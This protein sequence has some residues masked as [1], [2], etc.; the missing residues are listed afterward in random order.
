MMLTARSFIVA[1][2]LAAALTPHSAS[3]GPGAPSA[4]PST[5]LPKPPPDGE[6]PAL[7]TLPPIK[8]LE[9]EQESTRELD[10]LLTR[11]T[12]E[13]SDIREAAFADVEKVD[14]GLLPAVYGRIQN[15]RES[16]DRDQAP[17]TIAA[18][19]KAA[20]D[21]RKAEKKSKKSSASEEEESD[22][23]RFVLDEP[24]PKDATWREVVELLAITR[25]LR[26]MGTT[27][28]VREL[29]ELRANFG[30]M[31]RVDLM[32]Q[33]IALKDKAVPALLESKKHD[34]SVVREFADK[35]L[36]TLGK[37]TPGEAVSTTDPEVLA[38]TLKAFGYVREVEAVDVL[39]SFANHDR[40]KV[41]DAARQAIAAIGEAGRF[42]LRDAYQDLTGEK[43]DK[44]VPWDILAKRMFWLY[45]NARAAEVVRTFD[46]GTTLAKDKDYAGAVAAFDR[47]LAVDPQFDR[48]AEMSPAYF[49]LGKATSFDQPEERLARLRK[50]RRLLGQQP[51]P[52]IDA[53]IAFTE[54]KMLLAEGR[55]DRFLL[56]RAV[57]LDPNHNEAAAL[58]ASFDQEAA[59]EAQSVQ[60]KPPYVLA[61]AI[62]AVAA[63]LAGV[64]ALLP[65][66]RKQA[67]LKAPPA[68]AEAAKPTETT[69]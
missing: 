50:A 55:P 48:R 30:E 43:I 44:S 38:D 69:P 45:D 54:A 64:I 47:V 63:L 33:V 41:R 11:L 42:R 53:E 68:A 25:M 56:K 66:G 7:A 15:I 17:R 28:A 1:V 49:E 51:A 36:D 20:R 12:S 29:I 3:S 46:S 10:K 39:L 14:A 60:P 8:R 65:W 22:W 57:E 24:R 52:T 23:L 27:A 26:V 40:R 13:K 37:V 58:L 59:R 61:G 35:A 6:L 67:T 19:R 31:L 2:S 32:R 21:A 62:A 9:A 18:A 4:E 16:L 5:S 34:A